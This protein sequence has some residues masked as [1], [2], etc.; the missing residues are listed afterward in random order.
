VSFAIL[1]RAMPYR[2]HD[3]IMKRLREL[4]EQTDRLRVTADELLRSFERGLAEQTKA[5]RPAP[6]AEPPPPGNRRRRPRRAR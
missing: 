5:Q 6:P 4:S 1:T 2:D 3:A